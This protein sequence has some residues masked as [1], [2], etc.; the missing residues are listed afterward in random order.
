MSMRRRGGAP[1]RSSL[2]LP[3]ASTALLPTRLHLD[4]DL[5]LDLDLDF[6]VDVDVDIDVDIDVDVDVEPLLESPGILVLV[7]HPHK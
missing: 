7:C 4:V 1:K 6:D 2:A 5:D 3:V